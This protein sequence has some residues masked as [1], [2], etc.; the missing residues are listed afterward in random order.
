[1]YICTYY[2]VPPTLRQRKHL[3]LTASEFGVKCRQKAAAEGDGTVNDVNMPE[4]IGRRIAGKPYTVDDMGM[5]GARILL[6]DDCV[7]KIVRYREKNA[8]TVRVMRWLEGR[9][10]VPKVLCFEQDTEYQY[11]LMSRIPGRMSCDAYWLERPRE[12]LALLAEGLKLLWSIDASGCP[13]GRDVDTELREAGSRV[14]DRRVDV[15]RVEPTTFGP[16]GFRDPEE[17]LNWLKDNRPSYEPVLSHGD[18]CLPNILIENGR[19]SGFLDLGDT[20]IGDKW[21]DI[22]LCH[23]SLKH[24]FDGSFGG[25]VYPDFDPD[26]LFEALGIEPDREKLRYYTLLDELF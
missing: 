20:G 5:S 1:M 8:D 12:L 15:N 23:R 7:L 18:F 2:N 26:L 10:P 14:A 24:N 6:F 11:L 17:L 22:A 21:R 25:K 9:L 13:R 4:N 19:I 3:R 16:G